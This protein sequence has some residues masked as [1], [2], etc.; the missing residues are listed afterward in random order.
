MSVE[1]IPENPQ[2]VAL[3]LQSRQSVVHVVD[4]SHYPRRDAF[5]PRRV[6]YTQDRSENG[7]G[8]DLPE[9]VT[10]GDLLRVSV[11]DV[12]GNID[13]E[14]LVRVVW[15]ERTQAGRARAGVAMLREEGQRPMMRARSQT[16]IG[17]E[18]ADEDRI[19]IGQ[20]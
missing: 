12:D 1:Q 16:A 18:S 5:A 4:Y 6:A 17:D 9:V 8:L 19:A 11:R 7:L 20:E 14:G 13:L 10:P 2:G 15:C 3:R